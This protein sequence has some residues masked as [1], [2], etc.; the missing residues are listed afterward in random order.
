MMPRADSSES[1]L[2]VLNLPSSNRA[3]RQEKCILI[4]EDESK[5]AE[6]LASSRHEAGLHVET[7]PDGIRALN[8]IFQNIYDG[9]ALDAMLP[10]CGGLTIVKQLRTR[11]HPVPVLIH[12]A[13]GEMAERVEGLEAGGDDYLAKPF[14]IAEVLARLKALLRRSRDSWVMRLAVAD[15]QLDVTRHHAYRDGHRILPTPQEFRLLECRMRHT[16]EVCPRSLLL[17]GA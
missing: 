4:V 14:G 6:I 15:L 16:P 12:S 9:V 3:N 8:L 10:G 11:N 13:R 7:C 17:S 2:P 1:K 5:T